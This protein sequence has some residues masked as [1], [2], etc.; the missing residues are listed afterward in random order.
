M[1]P[2]LN[3]WRLIAPDLLRYGQTGAPPTG[4]LGYTA[5]ADH[6]RAFMDAVPPQAFHLLMHDLGGVLGLDWAAENEVFLGN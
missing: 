4:S 3:D 5:Y 1:L 6:L 2:F